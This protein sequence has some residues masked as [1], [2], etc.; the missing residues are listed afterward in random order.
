MSGAPGPTPER[1]FD[2]INSYHKSA[3]IK[4]A[5]E[6]GIFTAIA[7][8]G[9][10]PSGKGVGVG[11]IAKRCRIAPKGARV[12]CDFTAIQGFLQKTGEGENATYTNAE[13]AALFLDRDSPAYCGGSVEFL[14]STDMRQH[15]DSLTD[16][17]R[18]G[19]AP[20]SGDNSLAPNHEMW[21]RF[22]R[23]MAGLMTMPAQ[24]LAQHCLKL[25]NIKPRTPVKVLDIAAG[26][27]M[28]GIAF[29]Q[30]NPAAHVIGQDW[31]V[32]LPVALEH[33]VKLGVADR[34]TTL[35][36]SAFEVN[37]GSNYD[38]VLLPNFLHHFDAATNTELLK[39]VYAALR[40]GGICATLEFAPDESRLNP[41][42]A[43]TFALIMLA[44]TPSGDAYTVKELT[45]MHEAAGFRNVSGSMLPM[46]MQRVIT[47]IKPG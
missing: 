20:L 38:I 36:G 11:E 39:K 24:M 33:A 44:T 1:F 27:G 3:A 42:G 21:I 45:A 35:P 17:V 41:P 10:G 22:A 18:N 19:G 4:A 30:Q 32:V 15:M 12:L 23:G 14:A 31:P 28:Y 29:A 34:Y 2:A 7:E 40:P 6:L 9:G 43:G 47:G 5:I 46:G 13:D 37:F 8:A 26:H 16:R 25:M